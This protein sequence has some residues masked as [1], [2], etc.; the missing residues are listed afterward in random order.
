MSP[1]RQPITDEIAQ[2]DAFYSPG[3]DYNK[4]MSIVT[5][6]VPELNI[7]SRKLLNLL[8]AAVR[9]RIERKAPLCLDC[10]KEFDPMAFRKLCNHSR[11]ALLFSGG[12]DSAILAALVGKFLPPDESIDLFNVAFEKHRHAANC[13][14]EDGPSSA[15]PKDVF[16]VPDRQTGLSTLEELKVLF[17]SRKWNFVEVSLILAPSLV[18]V[19]NLPKAFSKGRLL[20]TSQTLDR[21]PPDIA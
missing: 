11:V 4:F 12:I 16:N 20:K 13:I 5:S 21:R 2:L 10:A 15:T 8:E 3:L 1:P 18:I 9:F 17:P 14:R 6:S 7:Y 19:E